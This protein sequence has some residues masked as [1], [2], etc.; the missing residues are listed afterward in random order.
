MQMGTYKKAV[1]Y[2][3]PIFTIA[4]PAEAANLPILSPGVSLV[5]EA[6][7]TC[8]CGAGGLLQ[9]MQNVLN[10]GISIG[11]LGLLFALVY[12][13]VLFVLSPTNPE[14]RSKA[15]TMAT[16][17]LIGFIIVLAAWLIVDFIMKLVYNPS[18]TFNGENLGPWNNI[19]QI[20]DSS[21]CI[22]QTNSTGIQGLPG[23]IGD[24][25]NDVGLGG[26]ASNS[27]TYGTTGAQCSTSNTACS[28][29]KLTSAGMTSTQANVMSCIAVTESS[30][31]PNTPPYNQTHPGSNSSACGTFQITKTTWNNTATGACS[32]FSNCTNASCNA[33]VAAALVQKSGYSSWTCPGC[34]NKAQACV[35]KYGG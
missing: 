17:A 30:G 28:V 24:I 26:V 2:A 4:L 13:G 11:V 31:N 7:K 5:P 15:R 8:A 14:A 33:Q 32:S 1:L 35:N 20:H 12:V 29:S 9:L 25:V 27:G 10:A 23:V 18:A 22:Q 3:L 34:N 19:L 16:N 6:C 21:V